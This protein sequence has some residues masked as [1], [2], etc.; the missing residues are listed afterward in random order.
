MKT[1]DENDIV[2]ERM[3][4]L[5]WAGGFLAF[6]LAVTMGFSLWRSSE[7]REVEQLPVLRAVPD[8]RLTDQDGHEVT[9]ESLRGKIWIA[10]FIFTRCQGPCPVMTSRMI[11]M[12]KALIKAPQVKLV[13]VSVD[14]EHDTP[15]VLKAYAEQNHA[16]PARWTF[17]TGDAESIKKLVTEG[18]MQPLARGDDGNPVH[19]S[20]FLVV[21]GQG[22]VRS[23]Q[24]LEDPE[25]I[26]KILM[27]TGNLL[28][29][30]GKR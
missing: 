23:A 2:G 5:G 22:M 9:N 27:D 25:L 11:E 28:R 24:M 10:D 19:G 30:Q 18:F 29:E 20:M 8:F 16:D 7:R 26:P 6:V 3:R 15:E 17:L 4:R 21:D 14:P 1:P 13:S 12:Q